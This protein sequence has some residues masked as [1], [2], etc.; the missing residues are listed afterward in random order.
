[1]MVAAKGGHNGENHNQN[2]VGNFLVHSGGETLIVDLGSGTYTREYFGPG[3]YEIL[4]NSS[5]GH[6]VPLVNGCEQ[7]TGSRFAARVLEHSS[8]QFRD[9]LE[10]EL[11]GAYPPEAG[12]KSLRRRTT[13]HRESRKVTVDDVI[14]FEG[15]GGTCEC[16]L[17]TLGDVDT[18]HGELRFTGRSAALRV[19]LDTDLTRKIEKL[20]LHDGKFPEPVTRAILGI[21]VQGS[22]GEMHLEILP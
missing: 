17:Y 11:A 5:R 16:P 21:P 9:T 12:L 15:E 10:L 4:V 3:R 14:L 8:S 19:E 13:L 7:S 2:D 1:M 22:K 18:S 20:D 6:N